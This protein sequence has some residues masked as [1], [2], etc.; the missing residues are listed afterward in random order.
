MLNQK[1]YMLFYIRD[2]K[3]SIKTAGG[4]ESQYNGSKLK[5]MV[6][7]NFGHPKENQLQDSYAPQVTAN[8]HSFQTTAISCIAAGVNKKSKIS[9]QVE[10]FSNVNFVSE[11]QE[12]NTSSGQSCSKSGSPA[13]H[14][15][16]L[17]LIPPRTNGIQTNDVFSS[18]TISNGSTSNGSSNNIK[19]RESE[20]KGADSMDNFNDMVVRHSRNHE[21]SNGN[22][23]YIGRNSGADSKINGNS[24]ENV[25][26]STN[27]LTGIITGH[28]APKL[29]KNNSN[30]KLVAGEHLENGSVVYNSIDNESEAAKLLSLEDG[31]LFQVLDFCINASVYMFVFEKIAFGS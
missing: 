26:H 20:I 27:D 18:H 24:H 19:K 7:L 31:F 23:N 25:K 21:V 9:E 30:G 1:A 16:T 8:M 14:D 3:T 22:G 4:S 6:P 5:K 2:K 15:A 17:Q 10:I 28:H 12:K 13:G 29:P 11:S